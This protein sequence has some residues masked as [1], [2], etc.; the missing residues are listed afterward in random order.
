[1]TAKDIKILGVTFTYNNEDKIPYVMPY[2]ERMGIDKLVVYDN[3]STDRTVEM[4]S[5]Y[6][7]VEIRSY[8]TDGNRPIKQ[9]EAFNEFENA[10]YGRQTKLIKKIGG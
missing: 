10:M 8:K 9:S 1:M 7:F 4:L 3:G 2:Y 5:N 6:P